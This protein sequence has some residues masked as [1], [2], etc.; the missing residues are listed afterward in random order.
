MITLFINRFSYYSMCYSLGVMR[1]SASTFSTR[2]DEEIW[3]KLIKL[4]NI[5]MSSSED[6]EIEYQYGEDTSNYST[7]ILKS[8][9]PPGM[10]PYK[11]N[12][13]Y[14]QF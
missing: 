10:L 5:E 8:L 6:E 4:A 3:G 12:Y 9:T 11:L 14:S 2:N 1:R 7:E 13:A